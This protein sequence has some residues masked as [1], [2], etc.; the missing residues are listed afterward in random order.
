M[1]TATACRMRVTGVEAR[2]L[3]GPLSARW[4]ALEIRWTLT[5]TVCALAYSIEHTVLP[6][7]TTAP[8]FATP[9]RRTPTATALAMWVPLSASVVRV[10]AALPSSQSLDSPGAS[11][12]VRSC[13]SRS[14]ARRPVTTA[15][16]RRTTVSWMAIATVSVMYVPSWSCT[17]TRL[18]CIASQCPP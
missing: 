9:I 6:P 3:V 2:L 11:I 12:L 4:A 5:R 14:S 17:S 1:L 18:T 8:T 16:R 13:L 10:D 7:G 15:R